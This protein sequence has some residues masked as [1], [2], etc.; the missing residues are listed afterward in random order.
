MMPG[1]K[2]STSSEQ[3]F[4]L[5]VVI[6]IMLLISFLA[7]QLILN[8][9]TELQVTFNAKSR[10]NGLSLAKAGVNMGIFRLLDKPLEYINDDY[11][12]FAEGYDYDAFIDT[13][14]ITYKVINE[15]GKIDLN[16]PN[17]EF[18]RFFL[19]Y[20][21][22]DVDEQDVLINALADWRDNDDLYRSDPEA[23]AYEERE[24][25]PYIARNGAIQDPAEF[26]LLFG[27]EKLAGRFRANEIF[28]VY[29][30]STKI[31][32]NSLSPT[33][34][35]FITEG[36][37]EKIKNYHEAHELN[38]TLN[39][40]LALQILGEERYYE[41]SNE[42]TYSFGSNKFYTIIARG[43]AG[44]TEEDLADTEENEEEENLSKK[45]AMEVTVIFELKG[46]KV[47]YYSWEEGWS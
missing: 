21:E 11:E 19:E 39:A 34:L 12:F 29:N 47:T 22:L 20:M 13:G 32:F 31:N 40:G 10:V 41:I 46:S 30:K 4:A 6:V 3:G 27:S 25:D 1:I 15:S 33:M 16:K 2:K 18:L 38:E 42:L 44:V 37:E 35:D 8:V 14:R 36:D 9:R 5:V 24:E 45:G 7:A 26:F 28:T 17:I 23:E 43:E